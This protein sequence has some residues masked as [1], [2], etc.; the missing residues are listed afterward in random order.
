MEIKFNWLTQS[1][2]RWFRFRLID[3]EVQYTIISGRTFFVL[4]LINY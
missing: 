4:D 1:A 2:A 3:A